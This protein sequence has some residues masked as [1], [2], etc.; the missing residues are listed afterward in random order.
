[1]FVVVSFELYRDISVDVFLQMKKGKRYCISIYRLHDSI[2]SICLVIPFYV[3][4]CVV[5]FL[6]VFLIFL[7]IN[8]YNQV[9]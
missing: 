4:K 1:M 3:F 6:K 9:F 8:V 7:N 5:S 2:Y